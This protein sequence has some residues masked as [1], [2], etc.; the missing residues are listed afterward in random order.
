MCANCICA[1]CMC[2]VFE[3]VNCIVN[4]CEHFHV[5][6]RFFF[7][8]M[9]LNLPIWQTLLQFLCRLFQDEMPSKFVVKSDNEPII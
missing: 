8:N 7:P 9:V 1:L 4:E 6:Q 3:R 2:I 5:L